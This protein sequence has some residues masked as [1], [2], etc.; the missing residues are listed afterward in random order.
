MEG[1]SADYIMD[2]NK[3]IRIIESIENLPVSDKEAMIYATN[4]IN[5]LEY[6]RSK[7]NNLFG[8]ISQWF[9]KEDLNQIVTS[10]NELKAL[11][12]IVS[13][14]YK[15]FIDSSKDNGEVL[16]DFKLFTD[17]VNQAVVRSKK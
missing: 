12:K 11:C 3:I 13:M 6:S 15:K 5:A 8:R 9:V 4:R 10:V 7:S 2:S 1:V 16:V 14:D 17:L